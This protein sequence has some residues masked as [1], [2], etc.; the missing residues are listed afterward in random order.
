MVCRRPRVAARCGHGRRSERPGRLTV[1]ALTTRHRLGLVGTAAVAIRTTAPLFAAAAVFVTLRI[2]ALANVPVVVSDDT[3][4]YESLNFLGQAT[5][6]WVVPLLWKLTPDPTWTHVGLGIAAWLTLA[7]VVLK[8]MQDRRVAILGYLAILILGL[9]APTIEWD[10]ALL[11]ES[12]SLSSLLFVVA[13]ILLLADRYSRPRAMFLV[14]ALTAFVFARHADALLFLL[15]A[16]PAIIAVLLTRRRELVVALALPLALLAG[17]AAF[18]LSR[19]TSIWQY[20]A[21][22]VIQNRVLKDSTA[23]AFFRDRGMPNTALIRSVADEPFRWRSPLVTHRP[24]RAWVK[25]DFRPTYI[26]YLATHP[27]GTVRRPLGD[28]ATATVTR[29]GYTAPQQVL[30]LPAQKLLWSSRPGLALLTIL[31]LTCVILAT[32]ARLAPRGM[33]I[34]LAGVAAAGLWGIMTWHQA[35]TELTRLFA[36]VSLLLHISLVLTLLYAVDGLSRKKPRAISKP[37]T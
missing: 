25:S 17:W 16:P 20:N 36:P 7:V 23:T 6:L 13:A 30:P 29:G 10:R 11:S 14:A 5:R 33:W 2:V 19:E 32:S 8:V 18:A 26:V 15:V 12:V 1:T 24:L 31:A 37:S 9:C 28:F 21:V 35:A 22:G 27:F 3:P 34:S 4:S